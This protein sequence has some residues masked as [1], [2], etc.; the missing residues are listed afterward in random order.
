MGRRRREGLR[1]WGPYERRGSWRFFI[2]GPDGRRVAHTFAT[3]AECE[4]AIELA[5]A[6]T[7]AETLSAAVDK[8]LGDL[9]A[10]GLKP[11][12]VESA[13][14]RLRLL[15]DLRANGHRSLS[16]LAGRGPELYE[17]VRASRAADTHRNAL[18]I[19]K[20]FGRWLVA[21]H[22][23]RDPFAGV[24]PTGRKARGADKAQLRVDEAR[25][26]SAWCLEREDAAATAVLA[27]LL[28]GVRASELVARDCRDVD[29]GG[30]LLW[31]TR[32]KTRA[33]SRVLE[34][35][36]LLRPRLVALV[37][38]RPGTAPLFVDGDGVRRTRHWVH[39]R[40]V[41]ATIGA[42]VPRV[43]PHGLRRTSASLATAAGAAAELVAAQLGH[44]SPAITA[45]AYVDPST[46]RSATARAGLR[47]LQG[48]NGMGNDT[49]SGDRVGR[50]KRASTGT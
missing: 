34:V 4:R 29:D 9:R 42:G 15:L 17:R 13:E 33:G 37:A 49:E 43:T 35:P 16:W 48:G 22:L 36:E 21:S 14:D 31:I 2:A 19:G 38:R 11:A 30:R 10:R 41:A 40:V 5:S 27:A 23:A 46:A 20:A 50:K 7:S 6:A 12:T 1:I 25:R 18:A 26:L 8:Y 44:A 39:G 32:T 47:V 28:L 45:R 3:R 24:K